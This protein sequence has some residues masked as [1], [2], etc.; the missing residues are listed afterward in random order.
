MGEGM[1]QQLLEEQILSGLPNCD[2]HLTQEQYNALRKADPNRPEVKAWLKRN[3]IDNQSQSNPNIVWERK[4][5]HARITVNGVEKL[6]RVDVEDFGTIFAPDPVIEPHEAAGHG[7]SEGGPK[8]SW[9]SRW[10]R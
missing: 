2:L 3:G 9:L 10:F 7:G 8:K 4:S 5:P 6:M 1:Q